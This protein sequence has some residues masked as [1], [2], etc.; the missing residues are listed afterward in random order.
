MFFFFFFQAEDGIRDFHVTGVQTCALPICRRPNHCDVWVV[1]AAVLFEL[2]AQWWPPAKA[3]GMPWTRITSRRAGRRNGI[4]CWNRTSLL[5]AV[6]QHFCK[7]PPE[8][9]GQRD[10]KVKKVTILETWSDP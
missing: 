1:K 5:V 7:P 2:R 3:G 4:P 6:R 10:E 8:L 9:L